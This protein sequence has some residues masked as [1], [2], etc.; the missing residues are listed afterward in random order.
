VALV[1]GIF[2]D[3]PIPTPDEPSIPP[4]IH[5][6]IVRIEDPDNVLADSQTLLENATAETIVSLD[7][8]AVEGAELEELED[9]D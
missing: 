4:S 5:F 1:A 8:T 2:P 3:G 7:G 9:E 6:A